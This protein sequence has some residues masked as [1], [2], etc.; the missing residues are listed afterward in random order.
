MKST[1]RLGRLLYRGHKTRILPAMPSIGGISDMTAALLL[2]AVCLFAS[3]GLALLRVLRRLNLR[4]R[5]ERLD[6]NLAALLR[7]AGLAVGSRPARGTLHGLERTRGEIRALCRRY[8]LPLHVGVASQ[9]EEK[10][11]IWRQERLLEQVQARAHESSP[12]AGTTPG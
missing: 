8:G 3:P 6:D 7:E 11:E 2:L 5:L 1:S 4:A 10:N 12:A 9:A